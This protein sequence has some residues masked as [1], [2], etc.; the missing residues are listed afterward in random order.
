MFT[1]IA[2]PPSA[3]EHDPMHFEHFAC[4]MVHPI[5]GETISSYK[6]LMHDLATADTWQMAFGRDFGRMAQGDNKTGQNGMNAM[7]VMTHEEIKHV[8]REGKKIMYGYPV[9]NYR[10]H[11]DE[12]NCIRMT[13][14]GNIITY[15]LSPSVQTANLNTA[16]L[17]WNSVISSKRVKY[18]CLDIKKYLFDGET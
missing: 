4:P 1:P 17:H 18:M 13:A 16:K 11:K 8:L 3:V 14:G 6:K 7:F 15:K 9:I 10:P 5:T 2:L 12:S